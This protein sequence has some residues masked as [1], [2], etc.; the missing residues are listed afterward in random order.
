MPALAHAQ[1]EQGDWELTLSGSGSNNHDFDTGGFTTTG[2]LGY[3]FNENVE[4]GVRQ[5]IIWADG[6]SSWSGDTRVFVDYHFD[7]DQWQPFVG[8]NTGYLYGDEF[9]DTWIA[10]PEVGVKY[11]LNSTTFIQAMMSYEFSL[12]ESF[13]DGAFFYGLGIGVRL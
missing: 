4:V 12:D 7:M 9:N 13:D 2:S 1:F 10:G 6:G 5:G 11:F 3:F 8:L